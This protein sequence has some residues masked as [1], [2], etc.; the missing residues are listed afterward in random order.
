[1]RNKFL[2]ILVLLP[3][4]AFSQTS[5]AQT[6]LEILAQ[7]AVSENASES[8]RAINE[9]RTLGPRGLEMLIKVHEKEIRRQVSQPLLPTTPEWQRLSAA[10]DAVSKQ[11]DSYLSGLYWHTDF[12]QAKTAARAAGKPILSLRLLGNLNEEFS[13][14]NSRFFRTIL[15]SNAAVSRMLRD[16]FILHWKSVRPAPHITIDFGDGRRLERTVTGNSIHYILDADGRP[17]DAL[18]GLYGP[19]AFVRG[20]EEAEEVFQQLARPGEAHLLKGLSDYHAARLKL[21]NLGWLADIE[22]SGGKI[23]ENFKVIRSRDG[24]PTA[25]EIAPLA[26]TKMVIE[27]PILRSMTTE[28]L[29]KVTDEALWKKIASLHIDD[30]RLDERSIGLIQRQTQKAFMADAA[31]TK[32]QVA[33]KNLVAK[34]EMHIA[35]DTVRNEYL[36]HTKLHAW[37]IADRRRSD[38]DRLNERVYAEL[39]LT[40]ASD[41]WLGLFES[42]TYVALDGGGIVR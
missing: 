35:L 18:P 30:A 28:M 31:K 14:A 32:P 15:Y 24:L 8:A 23:P 3:V 33:L 16:R 39:F 22:S 2:G 12:D 40:P 29:G 34:L 5:F 41:P 4:L 25:I 13:C 17:I 27:V 38:L 42:S 9:L 37:L 11:K 19:R 10:L 1:M 6:S 7:K 21:I 36:L 20:L 26:I